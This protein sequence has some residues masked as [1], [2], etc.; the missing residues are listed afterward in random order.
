MSR[1]T[2]REYLLKLLKTETPNGYRFDIANYLHNPAY[3]YEYPRFRKKIAETAETV[4]YRDVLYFKHYDGSG[5]YQAVTYEAPNDNEGWH[6]VKELDKEVLST[7][8]RFNLKTLL[9][10]C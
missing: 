4:T 10:Y 9:S 6:I 2:N 1:N 8:N 7:S 5:E 3:G